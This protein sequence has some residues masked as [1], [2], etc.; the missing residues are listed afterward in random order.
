MTKLIRNFGVLALFLAVLCPV[1]F[2]N[3]QVSTTTIEATSSVLT[4]LSTTSTSTEIT[5]K[6]Q[7]L[8]KE[9]KIV[10]LF[11]NIASRL[12]QRIKLLESE[13][14]LL[15]D[16]KTSLNSAQIK[17]NESKVILQSLVTLSE[18]DFETAQNKES[19]EQ[20]RILIKES[21]A[22][23]QETVKNINQQTNGN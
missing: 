22:L 20:V 17:I 14:Y 8:N 1:Y 3:A 6:N 12:D 21:Y 16:A 4:N 11:D 19:I 13:A 5:L 18:E 23:L 15:V 9:F 10:P 2:A 7:I